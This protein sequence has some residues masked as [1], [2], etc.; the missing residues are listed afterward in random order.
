MGEILE[1]PVLR[2]DAAGAGV[3]RADSAHAD[4][5]SRGEGFCGAGWGLE[6]GLASSVATTGEAAKI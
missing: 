4:S 6:D 3:A 1:L 5:D 2:K